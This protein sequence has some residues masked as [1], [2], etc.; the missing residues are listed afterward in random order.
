MVPSFAKKLFLFVNVLALLSLA[1]SCKKQKEEEEF[2][3][4][5]STTGICSA[6]Y[7]CLSDGYCAKL[8]L[9][10]CNNG[11]GANAN[12]KPYTAG[13]SCAYNYAAVTPCSGNATN[14]DGGCAICD[15]P[16]QNP[17]DTNSPILDKCQPED[18]VWGSC[19]ADIGKLPTVKCPSGFVDA[20]NDMQSENS[21]GCECNIASGVCSEAGNTVCDQA[22]NKAVIAGTITNDP[23]GCTPFFY[24]H[25]QD[26]HGD[27]KRP[28]CLCGS[29]NEEKIA[30]V[31][32]DCDDNNP[33][34]NPGVIE[35]CDG[36]NYSCSAQVDQGVNLLGCTNYY[37]DV[38]GDGYGV[39]EAK[40]FCQPIATYTATK[41]GDF[42]DSP[43]ECGKV[44]YPGAEE[45]VDH[46]D[47]DGDGIKKT[48]VSHFVGP[49]GGNG[50]IDDIGQAARFDGPSDICSDGDNLY[51]AD[52]NNHVI[53]KI[54]IATGQVTT[55]AGNPKQSGYANGFGAEAQFTKPQYVAT[56]GVY[57]FVTDDGHA[58][59]KVAIAT[60]EVTTLA[61]TADT[62]GYIDG[63][64]AAA[65][66]NRPTGMA[67]AGEL[68]FVADSSNHLIRQVAIASAEVSTFV[69][70]TNKT[71]GDGIGEEVGFGSLKDLAIADGYLYA[72]EPFNFKIRKIAIDSKTV[73]SFAESYNYVEGILIDNEYIYVS[74]RHDAILKISLVDGKAQK[75]AGIYK[76]GFAD[77]DISV[78]SF[79]YPSG[80]TKVD[81]V[82][83]IA[84]RDNNTV[85]KLD[86]NSQQVTTFAGLSGGSSY[87]VIDKTSN[88]AFFG[89]PT[90]IVAVADD[91]Y[92][93]D[94]LNY[95]RGNIRKININNKNVE[96][97]AGTPFSRYNPFETTLYDDIGVAAY[98]NNSQGIT[99]VGNFLYVADNAAIRKADIT[100][101]EITTLVGNNTNL[102][103]IDAVGDAARFRNA[104]GIAADGE[105]LFITDVDSNTIRKVTIANAEVTTLAGVDK[106][107]GSADGTGAIARFN[108]KQPNIYNYL[109]GIVT[110]GQ[111]LYVADVANHTI[112]KI[113]IATKE[114]TTIAG[115]AGE[116]GSVD[117]EGNA[118]RFDTPQGLAL[119]GHYLYVADSNN[120]TIRKI[121]LTTMQ[122]S[123]F[124]GQ[125]GTRGSRDGDD[126]ESHFNHPTGLVIYKSN[127]YIT[128]SGNNSI[129]VIN[130]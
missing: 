39:G 122:V 17:S 72:V 80:I 101:T 19:N 89:L 44:S 126:L 116:A 111:Y 68:L 100:T 118:A 35:I 46:C 28:L 86:L 47:N 70:N 79:A 34:V 3:K 64:G 49:L 102:D 124:A 90:G 1:S 54:V 56:N 125:A 98:F 96:V 71:A 60:G 94:K 20:D 38:D 40:C 109:A 87:I 36:I 16:R 52:T 8:V 107:S 85:R 23:Q 55:L 106:E 105:N 128:N 51:V 108:F 45:V 42:D 6:G 65:R 43:T 27:P 83:Y 104:S 97:F 73:S 114:V 130:L 66:F 103:Y 58:I 84:E 123:T 53:R 18:L 69:G 74:Y 67:V 22:I 12:C 93:I 121:D 63:T 24:D 48:V 14:C 41:N 113:V 32:D 75:I 9:P 77:G 117:G 5:C 78:A 81:N 62:S 91:L 112:R 10:A 95:S 99:V 11:S 31:G 37:S 120:N 7:V 4:D 115:K 82:F 88:A 119:D 26:E 59:R 15:C 2:I 21:N 30:L 61:G 50:W 129:R 110:D 127:L 25:D 57:V 29:P 76:V 33:K 13:E 92:V